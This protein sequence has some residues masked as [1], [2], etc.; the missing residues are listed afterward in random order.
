LF[1]TF[2]LKN[3]SALEQVSFPLYF[4]SISVEFYPSTPNSFF[5][6]FFFFGIGISSHQIKQLMQRIG[7]NEGSLT[8][9]T[10]D[11]SNNPLED[12]GNFLFSSHLAL[13]SGQAKILESLFLLNL[14]K[15]LKLF[16]SFNIFKG[17]SICLISSES[18]TMG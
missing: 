17:L 9:S 10:I 4:G 14:G 5:L 16:S 7:N 11:L 15:S 8:V 2:I 6:S 13:F 12:K 1:A 18:S 3:S